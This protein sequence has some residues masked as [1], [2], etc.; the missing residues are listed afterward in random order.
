MGRKSKQE[1]RDDLARKIVEKHESIRK[2][3][4]LDPVKRYVV[5][6]AS[7]CYD[8]KNDRDDRIPVEVPTIGSVVSYPKTYSSKAIK[9]EINDQEDILLF[10]DEIDAE[11]PLVD[12]NNNDFMDA[13]V[14]EVETKVTRVLRAATLEDISSKPISNHSS[15]SETFESV[16]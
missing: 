5:L 3:I 10:C 8:D 13:V 11:V 14:V 6:R 15:V 2:T 1:I 9:R 12:E 16:T 4:K 7:Y